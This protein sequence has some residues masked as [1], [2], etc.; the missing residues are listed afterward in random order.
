MS[1]KAYNASQTAL[2]QGVDKEHN[3]AEGGKPFYTEPERV[4]VSEHGA[5]QK[6][7][8]RAYSYVWVTQSKQMCP[9][10]DCTFQANVAP[11]Y[12]GSF[13]R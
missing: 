10:G 11:R 6:Q 9:R 2:E 13:R 5:C 1:Q 3:P 4:L 7:I 12:Y 8:S